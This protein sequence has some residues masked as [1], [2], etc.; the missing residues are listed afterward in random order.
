MA[1]MGEILSYQPGRR[2]R[3]NIKDWFTRAKDGPPDD[4]ATPDDL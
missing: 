1:R 3:A 2:I 4:G